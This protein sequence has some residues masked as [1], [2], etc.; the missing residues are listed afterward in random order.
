MAMDREESSFCSSKPPSPSSRSVP[1]KTESESHNS[2]HFVPSS[3]GSSQLSDNQ[4][5]LPPLGI[6][7]SFLHASASS[8]SSPLPQA[9]F[10]NS[11]EGLEVFSNNTLS[12]GQSINSSKR[13]E[14]SGKDTASDKRSRMNKSALEEQSSSSSSSSSSFPRLLIDP[15]KESVFESLKQK[16]E[17]GDRVAQFN[18]A[19]A[20]ISGRVPGEPPQTN[21]AKAFIWFTNAAIAGHPDA[22]GVLGEMYDAGR[23]SRGQSIKNDEEAVKWY[24][25]AAAQGVLFAINNL[26]RMYNTGRVFDSLHPNNERAFNYLATA[27]KQGDPIAQ[28]RLGNMYAEG[29]V[30]GGTP[31]ENDAKAVEWLTEAASRRYT[32]AEYELGNMY[33]K[34]RVSGLTPQESNRQAVEWYKRA[35]N[36]GFA[37][38][39]YEL[40]IMYADGRGVEGGASLKN[41]LTAIHLLNMAKNHGHKEAEDKLNDMLGVQP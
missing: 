1:I 31:Q 13:T 16:A 23:V 14:R 5:S 19:K 12:T 33:A 7:L 24:R 20:Y 18:L 9:T 30:P 41:K 39:E 34:G 25:K 35:V 40:G 6:D 22:Q 21:D 10:T 8:S 17:K 11:P 26:E 37:M 27:A 2:S 36:R 38:A 32:K 3:L 29:Q 15:L 28:Y 4:D